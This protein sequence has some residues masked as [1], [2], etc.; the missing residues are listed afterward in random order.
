M[1]LLNPMG[2]AWAAIALPII[3]L[4]ILRIR[5]RRQLVP[6]LMFW[7]QIFQDTAPRSLWR[8]LRHIGARESTQSPA[9]CLATMTVHRTNTR[10]R[11]RRGQASQARCLQRRTRWRWR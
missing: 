9:L 10:P 5:R 1:R 2:L 4:Y 11:L 3:G 8:R 7:D 6:T